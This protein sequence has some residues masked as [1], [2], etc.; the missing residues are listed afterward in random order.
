LYLKINYKGN[1]MIQKKKMALSLSLAMI[2]FAGCGTIVDEDTEDTDKGKR[3]INQPVDNATNSAPTATQQAITLD[4]D[5]NKVITFAGMDQDGDTLTF[6]VVTNPANGTIN[7]ATYTPN[8][9]FFGNDSFTFKANDGTADSDEATVSIMVNSVKDAPIATPQS[10]TLDEDTNKTIILAGTDAEDDDLTYTVVTGPTNGELDGTTYTP[11]AD[12]N[13]GDSF[14]FIANDGDLN[15][16]PAT[17]SITINP[18][19]DIP[20]ANSINAITL[21]EDTNVTITL[22]GTDTDGT[23][24]TYPI[25]TGPTSGTFDGTTYTPD[26]N[27]NGTDSFIFKAYDGT[28]D[29]NEVTVNITVTSVNDAPT[30]TP[31]SITLNEDTNTTITLSGT[32]AE[33][34]ALTYTVVTGPTKGIFDGTIY[35]PNANFNGADSFTF[36]A[37]DGDLNST[38][39]TMNITV[40]SV[41]DAPTVNAG[42]DVSITEGDSFSPTSTQDDIDGFIE[43]TIW[44]ENENIITFPK[45]DFTVGEHILTVTVT[46]NEGLDAND[47]LI[48]TVKP[49]CTPLPATGQTISHYTNDDGNLTKGTAR[50]FD[51]DDTNNTVTDNVTGL[52]WQDNANDGLKSFDEAGTYCTGLT[53]GGYEDWRLPVIKELVYLVDRGAETPAIDSVFQNTNNY[54]WSSTIKYGSTNQAWYVNFSTGTYNYTSWDLNVRCVREIEEF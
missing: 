38:P 7:G 2:L 9:N 32:D 40:D 50:S 41:N 49:P 14:T 21:D 45:T 10:I 43:G 19:N 53:L 1:F 44:K 35:T 8:A 37:N 25:V 54:Y 18:I 42:D 6:E 52:M 51:R 29:S 33:N 24:L 17:I 20:T 3:D 13:E 26:E 31:Q 15:S 5:G 12:F 46:D 36:I 39:A 22:T 48:L 28:A 16:T 27:F 34:N 23:T 30:A 47:T 11:N 4:E